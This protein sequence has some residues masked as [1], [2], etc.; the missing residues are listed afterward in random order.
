MKT[1]F[2][3]MLLIIGVTMQNCS[4]SDLQKRTLGKADLQNILTASKSFDKLVNLNIIYMKDIQMNYANLSIVEKE[5]LHNVSEKVTTFSDFKNNTTLKERDILVNLS[6]SSDLM[7]KRMVRYNDLIKELSLNYNYSLN[8]LHDLMI[9]EEGTRNSAT[10][11]SGRA[12]LSCYG[13][14]S[15]HAEAVYWYFY[16]ASKDVDTAAA[17][18]KVA[19]ASCVYGCML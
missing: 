19:Y 4:D 5:I 14:C 1:R 15:N 2:M 9:Q 3:T 10:I 16:D 13:A 8:D 11:K 18:A 7:T 6:T 17:L 12:A